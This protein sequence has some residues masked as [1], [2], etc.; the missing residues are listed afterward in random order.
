MNTL[1]RGRARR[2]SK[3]AELLIQRSEAVITPTI[4][5]K[6]ISPATPSFPSAFLRTT[7]PASTTFA[8]R[9][10]P[11]PKETELLAKGVNKVNNNTVGE[12][13]PTPQGKPVDAVRKL[14]HKKSQSPAQEFQTKETSNSSPKPADNGENTS[15]DGQTGSAQSRKPRLRRL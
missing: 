9:P 14:W 5:N 13:E 6:A 8:A 15:P 10:V 11:V 7:S 4:L 12:E 2:V 1:G 3:D